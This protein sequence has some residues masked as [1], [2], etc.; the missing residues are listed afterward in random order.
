M[1]DLYSVIQGIQPDQQDIVEAELLAQQ[2]LQAKFTDLDLREGTGIR[3]L[4]IRP[5][6]FLLALCKKGFDYYFSQNTLSGIDDTSDTEIVDNILG[7]LFLTRSL[8][9]QAVINARLYFAR[10]K[11]ITL[12]TSTSFSTEGSLLFFPAISST[13]PSTAMQ[14]DSYANEWYIDIDLLASQTGTSYNIGSG[15]LL[16]FSNFDPYFLHAEI[17]YLSQS[18]TAAETNTKFISRAG[19][20]ISTRNLVNKPSTE[21]NLKAN[22]NYL[23]RILV[24]SAGD[25]EIYRDQVEVTGNVGV[26]V[27]ASAMVLTDSNLKIQVTLAAHGFVVG[28]LL[29]ITESSG[30]SPLVLKRVAVSNVIDA[31]NF[32]ILL[33]ITVAPRSF[34]YPVVNVVQEDIWIHQGGSAD[35]HLGEQ[36]A[37]SLSQFTL[38]SGG[39]CTVYGPVYRITQ[40]SVAAGVTPDTVPYP[41]SFTTSYSAFTTR[42]DI[43][44]SQDGTTHVL[45][46][47]AKSH[48]FV[49]GRM[50]EINGWP[51]GGSSLHLIVTEVI[52]QDNVILGRNLSAYSPGG[53]LTP[54]IK[55]VYPPADVGFS[56]RQAVSVNFGGGHAGGLVTLSLGTFSNL[57]SIQTYLEL[58]ENHIVCGD[59]LARGFDIYI[60]NFDVTVYD[61]VAPTSGEVGSIITNFLASLAPGQDFILADLVANIT[62]NGVSKLK[63]PMGVT[64]SFYTKDLLPVQTGTIVDVLS[65][66]NSS[67]IFVL[68]TVTTDVAIPLT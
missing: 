14:L 31:S 59:L 19:S 11:S 6:A 7:N 47:T 17:N 20:A 33:P 15:S 43:S 63:T 32:K 61:V 54:S 66:Y 27:N 64:Y 38:D 46:L 44:L 1:A 56:T 62:A 9:T 2:I 40:S 10:Q 13:Y 28:Q 34:A 8:G 60:L 49:V 5:S 55:Y 50:V 41:T 48:C 18:S 21:S 67:S 25:A 30:G 58:S 42:S 22:F 36:V 35:T 45:T 16:Y 12:T 68:G 37:D 51:T 52:D 39:S 57:T 24:T 29:N 53:G 26:G 23:S 3:D 4:V 65:T